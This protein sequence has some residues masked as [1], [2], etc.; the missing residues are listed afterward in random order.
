M[1]FDPASAGLIVRSV[2]TGSRDGRPTR[3][4][5]ASRTYPT[6][7]ADLWDAL[8]DRDRIPRWFLPVTGD[9]QVGGRFQTQ[10]NAGGVVEAC[11]APE[12]FAI[13]WEYAGQVSW[14]TVRLSPEAGGAKTSLELTHEAVVDPAFWAQ[15][16]P[17]AVGVG[18]DLGLLGL[19]E[20]LDTGE[21]VDPAAAEAWTLS[22]EGVEF[23][24]ISAKGWAA[25][26]VA[27]GDDPQDA[28]DAADR[29]IAFYTVP[30]DAPEA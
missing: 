5:V 26:A 2:R 16:G 25:A 10:G 23:V 29:T 3:I 17:G 11:D 19:A 4:A 8:T 21:A 14:V 7:R 30:P 15:F 24:T 9:L 28:L 12:R 1:S 13:T 22:P 18:W 20:H 6:D 27:D